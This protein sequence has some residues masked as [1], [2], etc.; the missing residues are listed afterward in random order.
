MTKRSSKLIPYL[1]RQKF[2]VKTKRPIS[3]V[4]KKGDMV[5]PTYY[6]KHV[7][8]N[9]NIKF[10]IPAGTYLCTFDFKPFNG[11]NDLECHL[12]STKNEKEVD[13][14]N[15]VTSLWFYMPRTSEVEDFFIADRKYL[16]AA[17]SPEEKYIGRY[18]S[19]FYIGVKE[20]DPDKWYMETDGIYFDHITME[21]LEIISR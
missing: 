15:K 6:N 19:T 1:E 2:V 7:D 11:I 12:I 4:F 10:E 20:L 17:D 21:D 13:W 16:V 3:A 5:C 18:F 8:K 14:S 9:G